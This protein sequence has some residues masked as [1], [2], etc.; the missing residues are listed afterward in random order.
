MARPTAH[1]RR[2]P[3]V[4]LVLLVVAAAALAVGAVR[5]QQ[6]SAVAANAALDLTFIAPS[7][8]LARLG[9]LA[10]DFDV[11]S[12]GNVL[13]VPQSGGLAM[14]DDDGALDSEPAGNRRFDSAAFDG[15]TILG[16]SGGYFGRLNAAGL[17]DEGVP[18]PYNA[19]RLFR[20]VDPGTVYLVGQYQGE[21]RI[22][23]F[24]EQGKY[25]IVLAS[26]EP[27]VAVADGPRAVWAATP[28]RVLKLDATGA[29]AAFVAPKGPGF[30]A[31]TGLAISPNGDPIIATDHAVWIANARGEA[32]TLVNDAGGELRQ[33]GQRTYVLD[34]K[35]G[36]LFYF[37]DKRG[38]GA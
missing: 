37:A 22:Y 13:L 33:R 7:G 24:A 5:Q 6:R 10:P 15:D 1:R 36:L 34:R 26:I 31:I 11:D 20:T 14:I 17:F 4:V 2:W 9:E 29:H 28:A 21:W 3:W 18:L 23:R 32:D 12:R 30:G 16:T 27:I 8:A 38:E 35:R 25:R 19:A